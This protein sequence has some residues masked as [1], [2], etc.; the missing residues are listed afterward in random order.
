MVVPAQ[1]QGSLYRM[2]SPRIP[3]DV[4]LHKPKKVFALGGQI[5]SEPWQAE[6]ILRLAREMG[7]QWL[8]PQAES[9]LRQ[10]KE[11]T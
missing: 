11:I 4:A 5:V 3:F 2:T 9:V 8:I 1:S 6:R 10:L 7:R